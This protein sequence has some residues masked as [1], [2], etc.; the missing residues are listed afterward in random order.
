M[1]GILKRL[2]LKEAKGDKL[3]INMNRMAGNMSIK[4]MVGMS[5]MSLLIL[6]GCTAEQIK[7]GVYDASYRK[8]CMDRGGDMNCDPEHKSYDEYKKAREEML[9]KNP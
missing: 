1:T 7:R 2:L 3:Q 5:F 4:T 6:S 9:K 8:Y